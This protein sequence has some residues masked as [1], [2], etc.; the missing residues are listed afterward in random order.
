[1]TLL[2]IRLIVAVVFILAAG[3]VAVVAT[4]GVKMESNPVK[5]KPLPAWRRTI[6]AYCLSPL[7]RCLLFC[8]G[9][10]W[11]PTKGKPASC[12]DAP[13]VV[14]N[15]T[16]FLDPIYLCGAIFPMAVGAREHVTVPVI[17]NVVK[18][19]QCVCVDRKRKESRMEVKDAIVKRCDE[20][21]KKG[22]WPRM[23]IFP[24]GTCTNGMALV[25]FKPGPFLPGL[26]VQPVLITYPSPGF[27]PSWV[28]AGPSQLELILR[29]LCRP[30]NYMEV[31]WLD[32]YTPS[33]AEKKDVKLFAQNVQ[34]V[35]AAKMNVPKTTHSYH[36]VVLQK[37]AMDEMCVF[38]KLRPSN[39][40]N[41]FSLCL[42]LSP[43]LRVNLL[44][45]P[46]K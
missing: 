10:Y 31:E 23:L 35:M 43:P 28:S 5:Q 45:T 1:M 46:Q 25:T 39:I 42:H 44:T 4:T 34:A 33:E 2:P 24:E 29:L 21:S 3:A 38:A 18:A 6:I 19:M 36:D 41:A 17:G 22:T 7:V 20:S 16:S 27:D 32:V 12:K 37:K 9:Y 26:P 30:I 14:A 11:I 8:F 40:L 13:M 15:H